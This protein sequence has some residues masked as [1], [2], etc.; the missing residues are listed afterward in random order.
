MKIQILFFRD[1]T[2]LTT[3]ADKISPV[4]D[5]MVTPRNK[6]TLQTFSSN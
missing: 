2:S 4:T 5:D 6:A 3:I 1:D